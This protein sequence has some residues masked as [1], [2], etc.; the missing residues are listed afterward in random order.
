MFKNFPVA[1]KFIDQNEGKEYQVYPS[2]I[3]CLPV[4]K[5]LVKESFSVSLGSSIDKC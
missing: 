3:F 1:K 5:V 4:P 2:N